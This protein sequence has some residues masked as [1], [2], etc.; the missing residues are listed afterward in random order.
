MPAH[1]VSDSTCPILPTEKG[2]M[3][4]HTTIDHLLEVDE[5]CAKESQIIFGQ[6]GSSAMDCANAGLRV[7]AAAVKWVNASESKNPAAGDFN[8]AAE[9]LGLSGQH[10][11]D[12]VRS[13]PDPAGEHLLITKARGIDSAVAHSLARRTLL[14][15]LWRA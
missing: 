14:Q 15:L 5:S 11:Y 2:A 3:E 6:L 12:I 13:A 10:L 8:N 9:E 4:K 1:V 7:F